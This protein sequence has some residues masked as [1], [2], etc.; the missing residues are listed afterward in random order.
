M[1]VCLWHE[2]STTFLNSLQHRT[3]LW[4]KR[5]PCGQSSTVARI[6]A[7]ASQDDDM[8]RRGLDIGHVVTSL[9]KG[10]AEYIYTTL[11]CARGQAENL[12]KQHKAQTASDRTSCRSPLANQSR[13]ILHTAAYWLPLV[14]AMARPPETQRGK[15]NSPPS[16]LRLLEIADR[17]TETASHILARLCCPEAELLSLVAFA[18]QK[19]GP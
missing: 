16:A 17:F 13:L 15:A 3:R 19:S 6:D 14:R 1:T 2:F 11:Y 5:L 12:I 7:S 8:L 9:N 18:L 10:S 4:R